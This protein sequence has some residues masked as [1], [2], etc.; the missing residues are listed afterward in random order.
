MKWVKTKI[1]LINLDLSM[2]KEQSYLRHQVKSTN[3]GNGPPDQ[4]HHP[5]H[6]LIRI[7]ISTIYI[8]TTQDSSPNRLSRMFWVSLIPL[9]IHCVPPSLLIVSARSMNYSTTVGSLIGNKCTRLTGRFS[10]VLFSS[11]ISVS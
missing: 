2:S 1:E 11:A 7:H 10:E 9:P 8:S 5:E 4:V 3:S 6:Y